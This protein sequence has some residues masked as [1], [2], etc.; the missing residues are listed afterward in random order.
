MELTVRYAK[1]DELPRV[2]ELRQTVN[3]LHA[4]GRP[5]FFRPGFC[6]ALREHV[7]RMF[8]DPAYDVIV[9][10]CADTVCGFAAV[11]YV[12]RP[13]SAYMR[14]RRFFHIEEF[15]VDARFRRRG[16]G[17]ALLDFC[18]A[19]AKRRGFERL[20]LDVWAF[21]E[22]AQRFYAA[23]GFRPYRSYLESDV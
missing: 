5:D 19:E 18:R 1:Y 13:A 10:C 14:A 16:V 11:Q 3:E 4:Q 9:A 21:N 17:T 15:G 6:D 8:D 2:N 23:A 12:D 20:E 7:Y 22:D